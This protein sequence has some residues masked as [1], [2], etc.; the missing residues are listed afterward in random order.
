[1]I[2]ELCDVWRR[3]SM[4]NEV[5]NALAGVDLKVGYGE[6]LAILGP[7]GSGKTTMLN[8]IGGLDTA[9]S[10]R[11]AVDGH[12]L[13]RAGDRILAAYRNK[14]VGFV[15]QN[16]NLQPSCSALEN[17]AL[18][19]MFAG[20][21]AGRRSRMAREG[22]QTVGMSQ[23]A[24]H[25][26]NQLSSGERQ[27]VAIARALVNEPRILLADEPTGNLD[28]RTSEL[29]MEL[30]IS[31]VRERNITLLMVT[32]NPYMAEFAGRSIHMRDGQISRELTCASLI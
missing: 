7:S 32:H 31:L 5:I 13:S 6:F 23:R 29:V 12:D 9:S 15:F 2:I 8:I 24:R 18:P 20:V 10:G 21:S 22:L 30:L 1:M 3:Y 4:G 11:V 16:F 25:L 19:L 27:R 17:V 14:M 28:T 26:P